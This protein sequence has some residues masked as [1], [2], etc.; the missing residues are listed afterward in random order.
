[1]EM[2]TAPPM[3]HANG[4]AAKHTWMAVLLRDALVGVHLV[5]AMTQSVLHMSTGCVFDPEWASMRDA[6]PTA[7]RCP[8]CPLCLPCPDQHCRIC[9]QVNWEV[10]WLP[11]QRRSL[12][13]MLILPFVL[14]FLLFPIGLFS[15]MPPSC[16]GRTQNDLQLLSSLQF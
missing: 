7:V 8:S 1:M 11:W 3:W 6:V 9:A 15:G 4:V 16:R 10:L 2:S 14:I 13:E 5:G 12:H